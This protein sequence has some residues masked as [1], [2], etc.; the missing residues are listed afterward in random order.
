MIPLLGLQLVMLYVA[1]ISRKQPARQLPRGQGAQRPWP[2]ERDD[3]GSADSVEMSFDSKKD[4]W[5]L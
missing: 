2:R 5:P 4:T 3:L 1:V